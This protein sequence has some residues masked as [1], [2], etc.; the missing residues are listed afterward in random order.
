VVVVEVR[1][2]E[3]HQ[4]EE[5]AHLDQVVAAAQVVMQQIKQVVLALV[6]KDSQAVVK[7]HLVEQ[8]EILMEQVAVAL[9][10]LAAMLLYIP[11][12][13][14]EQELPMQSAVEANIMLAVVAVV[15]LIIQVAEPLA[16]LLQV[17]VQEA[18]AAAAQVVV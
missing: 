2:L 14:E 5:A 10:Q 4:M 11:R 16:L 6:D 8:A 3:W 1:Y 13:M 17:A 15:M 18:L 7:P 12:A 9:E